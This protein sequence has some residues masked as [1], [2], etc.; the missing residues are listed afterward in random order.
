MGRLDILQWAAN[1]KF[2]EAAPSLKTEISHQSA[3]ELAAYVRI[4]KGVLGELQFW[5]KRERD[6]LKSEA[7]AAVDNELSLVLHRHH[8]IADSIPN[9]LKP[10][11][12][13][14]PLVGD[15]RRIVMIS[16]LDGPSPEV[17]KRL[18]DDAMATEER[19]LDGIFYIDTRGLASSDTVGSYGWYDKK[20]RELARF[21]AEKTAFK[22][23]VDNE[24]TLFEPGSA[25]KAALYCGWYALREYVDAFDWVRGSV[26]FHVASLEASTLREKHSRVWCKSMLEKGICATL[27][28]VAEPYLHSFPLPEQF[29]PLLMTGEYTLAEVYFRTIPHLSWRQILVGDPL[30]NPF[31][32]MPALAAEDLPSGLALPDEWITR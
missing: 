2:R 32:K 15:I 10:E 27:G 14:H 17:A 21:L 1:L 4:R 13:R 23:T 30:Y 19:G 12:D 24:K 11:Y 8:A 5:H 28:A 9:P 29:F 7:L 6:S 18:V 3:L 25:P 16:R 31:K 20:L 26:G 22:V